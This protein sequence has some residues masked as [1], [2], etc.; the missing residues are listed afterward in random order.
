MESSSTTQHHQEPQILLEN[1]ILIETSLKRLPSIEIKDITKVKQ[2]LSFNLINTDFLQPKFSVTLEVTLKIEYETNTL[3]EIK[4]ANAGSFAKNGNF[5][6]QNLLEFVNVNAPALIFPFIRE[7]ISSLSQK[8]MVGPI[9][10]QP[11]NFIQMYKE[12]Q[13]KKNNPDV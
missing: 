5:L 11:I 9:L 12:S 1:I 8:A 4:V 6:D 3:I 2:D 7:T 10:L 13:E